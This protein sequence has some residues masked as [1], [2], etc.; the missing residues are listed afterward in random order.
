MLPLYRT[1]N[2]IASSLIAHSRA[3]GLG[4]YDIGKIIG[5][6][7]KTKSGNRKISASIQSLTKAFPDYIGQFQKMEGKMRMIKYFFKI[8][9]LF[10]KISISRYYNKSSEPESYIKMTQQFE[11]LS[12]K[13]CPY[14]IGDVIKFPNTKYS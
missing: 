8:Y 10:F 3:E 9:I 5:I 14:K 7:T 1:Q 11:Q 2:D 13:K 4:R 12:K 6:N